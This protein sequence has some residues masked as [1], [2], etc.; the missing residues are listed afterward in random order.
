MTLAYHTIHG[1]I[2]N[3]LRADI[4]QGAL[5]PGQ[6][7]NESD[8]AKRYKASRTPIREA[9]RQLQA[10][11]LVAF[12]PNKGA[13]VTILTTGQLHELY[14]TWKIFEEL[15]M[16]RVVTHISEVD[17][18]KAHTMVEQL[19]K[20]H[21]MHD[22]MANSILLFRLRTHLSYQCRNTHLANAT[23]AILHQMSPLRFV[24]IQTNSVLKMYVI[25]RNMLDAIAKRS[26]DEVVRLALGGIDMHRDIVF[27]EVLKKYPHLVKPD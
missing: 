14:D 1:L 5:L 6:K 23:T 11:G 7:L 12:S 22:Y 20:N 16:R 18:S 10:E 9:I 13:H 27:G 17:L 15:V 21:E 8:L 2:I 19:I 25:L 24:L 4:V 3:Q 26:V